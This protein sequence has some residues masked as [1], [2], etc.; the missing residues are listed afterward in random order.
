MFKHQNPVIRLKRVSV[1]TSNSVSP[2]DLTAS[3]NMST[4]WGQD[5]PLASMVFVMILV[6]LDY[7]LRIDTPMA[8]R[9][10]ARQGMGVIR[11][12]SF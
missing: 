11:K 1:S 6:S 2:G 8:R 12:T 9:S 3:R 5:N 4:G 7:C 10:N